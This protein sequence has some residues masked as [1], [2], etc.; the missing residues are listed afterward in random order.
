VRQNLL[1]AQMRFEL[2]EIDER[3]FAAIETEALSVLRRKSAERKQA[4]AASSLGEV[5]VE[6]AG[7]EHEPD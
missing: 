5:A 2:G 1:A 4:I 7:D 3:E 6:F